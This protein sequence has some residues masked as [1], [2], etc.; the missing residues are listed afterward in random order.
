ML[1]SWAK[2]KKKQLWVLCL[3]LNL[4]IQSHNQG[5]NTINEMK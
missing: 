1:L 5:F 4:Q 2:K 3:P